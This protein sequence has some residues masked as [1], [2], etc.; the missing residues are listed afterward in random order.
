MA[1]YIKSTCTTCQPSPCGCSG[2]FKELIVDIELPDATGQVTGQA[3]A[4]PT[5]S[6]QFANGELSFPF[7]TLP[8]GASGPVSI[9]F[10]PPANTPSFVGINELYVRVYNPC[11]TVGSAFPYAAVDLSISLPT[12]I[13]VNPDAGD[14]GSCANANEEDCEEPYPVFFSG[15]IPQ[16]YPCSPPCSFWDFRLPTNTPFIFEDYE[17]YSRFFDVF[18]ESAENEV[19]DLFFTNGWYAWNEVI[20][21]QH[22]YAVDGVILNNLTTEESYYATASDFSLD[23]IIYLQPQTGTR[24]RITFPGFNRTTP[25]DYELVWPLLKQPYQFTIPSP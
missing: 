2:M 7:S 13:R 8:V 4:N 14:F 10:V 6:S 12:K 5:W 1:T 21:P 9:S 24:K 23:S 22:S 19:I 3:S 11:E 18:S 20:P 15:Y 25:G 16:P 17:T